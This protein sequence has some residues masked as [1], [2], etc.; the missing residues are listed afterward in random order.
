[1]IATGHDASSLPIALVRRGF[2]PTGG[3]EKFLVRFAAEAQK[4]GR[5]VLLVTDEPWPE[6][7]RQGLEQKILPG[8]SVWSFARSVAR[9][10]E[11]WDGLLFSFERLFSAD[12]YRAG[13][14]VYA[15]WMQR[16]SEHDPFL[17]VLLRKVS[18]KHL[19]LLELEKRCFSADH[20]G[21]VIVNSRLVAGEIEKMFGYPRERMHLVRNGIPADF[22]QGAP[23][24][25]EARRQLGLPQDGFV[26][27]FAGTGW[28]R[29]G[30]RFAIAAMRLAD[31]PGARLV[32]AGR[33]K[34]PADRSPDT[35]FLGPV[36]DVRPLLSAADVFILPTVYDP[37]SNACLEALAAGLPVITTAANGCAEVLREGISGSV[38]PRAN[39][40][41]ALANA[42][43]YW[44]IGQRASGAAGEC[45]AVLA[46][47]SLEQNVTRTLEILEAL[48]RN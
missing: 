1:V 24:K 17:H 12:C 16:R 45:R 31:I 38:V 40:V 14:G 4:R 11:D 43:R 18:P 29:K 15:A 47:C 6:N 13:D 2:S 19:H 23:D 28:K 30:L 8:R 41:Q 10:R 5:R 46:E 35:V 42:L 22:M 39:D 7:A 34:P 37:F 25:T 27:A 21:A 44:S 48:R 33:G 20:T 32:V 9:W 26:A 3:A 36:G